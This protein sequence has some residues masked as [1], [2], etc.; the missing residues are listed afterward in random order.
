[1]PRPSFKTTILY[2]SQMI[3]ATQV[4]IDGKWIG[5][6]QYNKHNGILFCQKK[7]LMHVT[8]W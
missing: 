7:F 2:N 4:S 3:K 5:K 1:M 6:M 8:T